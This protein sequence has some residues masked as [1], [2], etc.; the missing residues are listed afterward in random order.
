MAKVEER[1]VIRVPV[2]RLWDLVRDPARRPQWDRSVQSVQRLE[3]ADPLEARF[4]YV[5]P[6]ALGLTWR[7]EGRYAV[8]HDHKRAAVQMERGSLLRPFR[9]LA[10][11]WLLAE[12]SQGTLLTM[13]VNFEPRLRIMGPFVARRVQRVLRQSLARLKVLAEME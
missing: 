9:R 5:A 10:G 1:I 4:F 11:T 7:W 12:H 2:D 13:N 8:F 6:L 3:S